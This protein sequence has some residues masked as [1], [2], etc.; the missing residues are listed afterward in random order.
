MSGSQQK[1]VSHDKTFDC[2]GTALTPVADVLGELEQHGIERLSDFFQ[3]D[4][5][6]GLAVRDLR[7]VH[8]GV[9]LAFLT[10][11]HE[12]FGVSWEQPAILAAK[13]S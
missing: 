8:A 4:A 2:T 5:A 12:G 10:S 3:S 9:A 13:S 6:G 11:L 7:A 1:G